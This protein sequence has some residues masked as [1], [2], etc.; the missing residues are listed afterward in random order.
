MGRWDSTDMLVLCS[1]LHPWKTKIS[2]LGHALEVC[3]GVEHQ[4]RLTASWIPSKFVP[5]RLWAKFSIEPHLVAVL[6]FLWTPGHSHVLLTL[7]SLW[8]S[9]PGLTLL[10]ISPPQ[11]E[12]CPFFNEVPSHLSILCW[13][14]YLCFLIV[15]PLYFTIKFS[16][17]CLKSTHPDPCFSTFTFLL[18]V[19]LFI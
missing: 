14:L 18:H 5:G 16:L 7:S 11:A 12:S 17:I 8:V 1:F 6:E 4:D 9:W 15:V 19:Y 3:L 10:A 13:V 2:L